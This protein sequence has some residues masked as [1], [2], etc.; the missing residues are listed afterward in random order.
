MSITDYRTEFDGRTALITGAASGIG[1]A[2]ARRLAAGGAAVVLADYDEE[3]AADAAGELQNSGSRAASVFVDVTDAASTSAAVRF[4][5]DAFGGLNLAVNN[6][7]VAGPSQPTGAYDTDAWSQVIAVNLTGVFHSLRFELP[8]LADEGGGAVVNLSS[9]LGVN[10]F[11][12]SP[13]YVA[14]KHGVIGLTKTAALEYAP[15]GVRVNALG[16]GFVDTPLL[17]R[18]DLTEREELIA[19]HPQGRL[20]TPE[21]MAEVTAFL[22]SERASFVEGSFHLVDGGYSAQ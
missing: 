16:P 8:I 4:A 15:Q 10:G 7:G 6:A 20:G 17:G 13:A 14:A 3:G 5:A 21:E 11:A 18:I 12:G 2:I 1:L 22:L 19:R 9:I